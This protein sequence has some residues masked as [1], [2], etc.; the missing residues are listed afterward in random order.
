M[1]LSTRSRYG[2]RLMLDMA[3]H[4]EEGPIQLGDIAKRQEIS[5]KY[6]EQIIIPLKKAGL[7]KSVR[8]SKGGHFLAKSPK[9]ITMAE[10]VAV[11]EGGVSIMKCV[12]RPETCGRSG[13]CVIR[14][15][16]AEV[17]QAMYDKLEP[18]TLS[19]LVQR[20]KAHEKTWTAGKGC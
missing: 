7:V 9:D 1:K 17:T 11:L 20:G 13:A 12:D 10:I 19:K 6:L 15:V 18:L 4:H 8:G 3:Q 2:A 16:W 5:L 14:Q